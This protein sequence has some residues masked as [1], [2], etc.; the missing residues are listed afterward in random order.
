MRALRRHA[1]TLVLLLLAVVAAV[2]VLVLDRDVVT[3]DEAESR[4]RNLLETWRPDDITEVTLTTGGRT[5]V[6]HRSAP[7]D[8][9][10]KL[11]TVTLDGQ[12]YPADEQTA[13]QLLGTLEFAVAERRVS[14]GAQDP[15]ALGLTAPKI[16][17][18]LVMGTRREHLVLGGS[19]PTPP[20]AMYADVKGRGVFV[21]TRQLVTALDV[22]VD[23]FRS[24]SLVPYLSTELRALH[25]DGEGGPRK[26]ARAP[27][28]GS[29]GDGFRFD[30]S[31]PEG[32][33]RVRAD[34]IDRILVSL[35]KMQAESYLPDGEGGEAASASKPRVTLTLLPRDTVQKTAILDVGAPC[36]TSPD[37][38][39]VVRRE[40]T[41]AA[42]CVPASVLDPLILPASELV[43]LSPIAA[44]L[45]EIVEMSWN[46]GG[47]GSPTDK[48]DLARANYGWHLRAPE[49]RQLSPDAGKALAEALLAVRAARIVPPAEVRGLDAPR[50]T[51]K[52]ISTPPSLGTPEG[53]DR[54][55]T[56]TIGTPE[57]DVVH[58]RRAED[59][60]VLEIPRADA[61]ALTP[62]ELALRPLKV[63][64]FRGSQV[65]KLRIQTADLVQRLERTDTGAWTLLEPDTAGLQADI[66]LAT[67]V[68][69]LAAGL[70]AQRWV[71]ADAG[72]GY[73]LASPR[74]VITLAVEEEDAPATPRKDG[75]SP[76][77]R[78]VRIEIGAPATKGSFARA[79]GS[80]A[81]FIAPAALEAAASRLLLDR[82]AFLPPIDRIT[83]VTLTPERGKPALATPGPGGFRLT[84]GAVGS[85]PARSATLAAAVRDALTNLMAE[86]AV[87]LGPPKPTQGLDRPRLRVEIT[88]APEDP[89]APAEPP[90][91]FTLGAGDVVRG[92]SVVY[93]RREGIPAT[94]VI[95]QSRI[96]PLLE[97]AEAGAF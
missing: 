38:L 19:A 28:G 85:D 35:G 1:T 40:P 76:P 46:G 30:G 54:V 42:A 10:R 25:L 80:T 48:L 79:S 95:A 92:T 93:A 21:V 56:L 88:L 84:G 44:R 68:A 74:L 55:E 61:D 97:A 90:M 52:V 13:D 69:D 51:L 33:A 27:W 37:L 41:R 12:T 2:V 29:R 75:S 17:L 26:L 96:R 5:A 57:G 87:S 39:L 53:N 94:Y 62:S 83:Q 36:P 81:V 82:S 15:A 6:L 9:G 4:K 86:E 58:V 18:D 23:R 32:T 8:A 43:D 22:P 16:T 20:G 45:D 3:T 7:D 78:E 14:E 50:A 67:D 91:R 77:L 66:G 72:S 34:L 71:S 49:D 73:G 31:T 60:L 11:W 47:N 70:T 64:D 24:R 65:R 89:R 59:D 63:L